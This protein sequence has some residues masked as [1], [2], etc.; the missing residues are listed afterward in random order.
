MNYILNPFD[1]LYLPGENELIFALSRKT[2]VLTGMHM[3]A[4][5]VQ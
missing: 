2:A 4:L 5:L 1:L 3:H